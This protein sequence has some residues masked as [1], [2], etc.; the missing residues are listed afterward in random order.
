VIV[1]VELLTVHPMTR[2]FQERQAVAF[3]VVDGMEG[4]SVRGDFGGEW[5]G[6]VRPRLDWTTRPIAEA[7]VAA[8]SLGREGRVL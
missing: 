5:S 7:A 2:H 3:H 1:N 6:A 4:D 8:P